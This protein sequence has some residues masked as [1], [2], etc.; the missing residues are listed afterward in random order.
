M[1]LL[2][3][4]VRNFRSIKG[5]SVTLSLECSDIIFLFGQNNAG[6]SSLLSAYEYL[7]RPKQKAILSDFFGFEIKNN[8]EIEATFL[9][10]E[11]DDEVFEN[12]GFDKW[13]SADNKIKFR[14]TWKNLEDEGQKETLD[15]ETNKYVINGFGGIEQHFTKQAPTPIRIPAFPTPKDLT[16][17]VSETVK[18]SVLKT[19]R[20]EEAE[21]YDEVISKIEALQDRILSKDAV[22]AKSLQANKNF[23]KVFPELTLDISP[24]EGSVFNLSAS[25]EKEFSVIIKDNRLPNTKQDFSNHGHG[26]IRQ[27]LFNFLGVVKNNLPTN[28]AVESNRKDFIILFEEPE[29]YLHPRAVKLLRKVLYELCSRSRFQIICASHSTMLIDISKPHTS[30]VRLVRDSTGNTSLYQVGENLFQSNYAQ[31]E[32]VQMLN[33]FD[34]N[35]CESFFADE[36][37]LVEGDTEAIVVRELL[38]KHF[39][40]KDIF[41]VNTGSKNNIPFFQKIY[42]HFNI[43]QHII[44]DSDT[45]F[46]Y[47][48]KFDENNKHIYTLKKNKDGN[49][50]NNSA[51]KIN[52]NI[53][54]ELENGNLRTANLSAR[55]VSI[56]NF[57]VANSY[58]PNPDKGKPLSAYEYVA[59]LTMTDN[60]VIF[61]FLKQIAG[62]EPKTYEFTQQELEKL[63]N[64]PVNQKKKL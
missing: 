53:W 24:I 42:N 55:Y 38:E 59:K 36:V 23:Q 2:D 35:I 7:V 6:K 47:E 33:R 3:I 60:P 58:S 31:K 48:I 45:R 13:V 19:L 14:K 21:A 51:W 11:G 63:V 22:A 46:V 49:P 62:A 54:T 5:D 40:T 44:H 16:T 8:I 57:E 37:I 26:V 64:E 10:D 1:K 20:D 25:L 61:Q 41:V 15:P 18:S 4:T 9:K 28:D 12:K 56:Y 50:K 32:M 34:P 52:N 29:A 30:L 43:K 17:F 39:P 27:T